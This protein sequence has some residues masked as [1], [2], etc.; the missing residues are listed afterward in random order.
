VKLNVY[1]ALFRRPEFRDAS[2]PR[3]T[4]GIVMNETRVLPGESASYSFR[5]D[6]P[7]ELQVYKIYFRLSRGPEQVAVLGSYFSEL[8][9]VDG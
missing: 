3:Q 8:I 9:R 2:W 5:L 1:G 6:A 7:D 4:G